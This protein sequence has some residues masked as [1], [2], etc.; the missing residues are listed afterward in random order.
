MGQLNPPTVSRGLSIVILAL[1]VT[2]FALTLAAFYPGYMTIDAEWVYKAIAG[3]LGDWQSPAMSIVWR[4]IDPI[5]PGPMSMFLLMALL[6][7]GGFG[8]IAFTI[9]RDTAG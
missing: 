2:G 4:V 7:W 1:L 5:A 6:Y 9:A 8:L 3:G